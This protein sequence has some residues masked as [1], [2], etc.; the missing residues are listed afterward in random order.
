MH[1]NLKA[2][3]DAGFDAWVKTTRDGGGGALDEAAYA[4][5]A[6]Q[7]IADPPR[8]FASVDPDLFAKV[9]SQ[10]LAPGPGPHDG[11]AAP[12]NVTPK[13]GS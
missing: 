5:L 7:S 1:F 6:K 9:I 12:A 4:Q 10:K 3:P 11:P 8:T 13:G 2:V